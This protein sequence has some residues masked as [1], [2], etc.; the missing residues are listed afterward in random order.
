MMPRIEPIFTDVTTTCNV[1][2]TRAP[3]ELTAARTATVATARACCAQKPMISL[4]PSDCR[5]T[6]CSPSA[7][8]L[9]SAA[10]DAERIIQN[11]TQPQ[12]NAISRP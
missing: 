11:S 2:P 6:S 4:A 9:A 1:P 7:N 5:S 3:R 10:I 8:M 12:R